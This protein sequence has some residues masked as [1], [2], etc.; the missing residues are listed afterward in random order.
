MLWGGNLFFT[1]R[2]GN[3]IS[4]RQQGIQTERN[5][6]K[7]IAKSVIQFTVSPNAIMMWNN[8]AQ[9]LN[10]TCPKCGT[11]VAGLK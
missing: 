1:N 4:L 8:D 5:K 9:V 2:S 7:K 6:K 11:L 10:N 3:A